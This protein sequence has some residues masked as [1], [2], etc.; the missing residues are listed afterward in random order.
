ME[1]GSI[2]NS[3]NTLTIELMIKNALLEI[4]LDSIL[5]QIVRPW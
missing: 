3:E 4:I 1:T 2:I 5:E